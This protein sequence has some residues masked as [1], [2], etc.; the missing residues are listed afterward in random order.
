MSDE[1]IPLKDQYTSCV[2]SPTNADDSDWSVRVMA[3][4]MTLTT[5][6]N[7]KLKLTQN[8]VELDDYIAELN[9]NVNSPTYALVRGKLNLMKMLVSHIGTSITTNSKRVKM[10]TRTKEC[11][12]RINN[13]LKEN[14]HV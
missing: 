4:T 1:T 13:N 9:I 11:L 7:G 10:H 8:G 12:G 2:K 14:N 6:A 3:G 5:S